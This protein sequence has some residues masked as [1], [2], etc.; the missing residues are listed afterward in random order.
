MPRKKEE[1]PII[2]LHKSEDVVVGD[3]EPGTKEEFLAEATEALA[4]RQPKGVKSPEFNAPKPPKPVG[5]LHTKDL[6]KD[7]VGVVDDNGTVIRVYD[8]RD[9]IEDPKAA[10]ETYV[11][12]NPIK[13][14]SNNIIIP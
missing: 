14:E 6:G 12:T 13:L 5:K 10:A 8:K 3:V 4:P 7:V 11:K 1:E 9:G 2:E